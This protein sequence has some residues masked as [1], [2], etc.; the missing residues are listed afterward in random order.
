MNHE[1][2]LMGLIICILAMFGVFI[3]GISWRTS[4]EDV[5]RELCVESHGKYD[6][7]IKEEAYS[8]KIPEYNEGTPIFG[9]SEEKE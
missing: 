8:I 4:R 1:F 9:M 5:L 6:F 2:S 3:L 7:C